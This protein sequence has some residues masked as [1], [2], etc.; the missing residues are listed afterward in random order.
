MVRPITLPSTHFRLAMLSLLLTLA[1]CT[2]VA[3]S[4]PASTPTPAPTYDVEE[5]RADLDAARALWESV[6]SDDYAVEY[7]AFMYLSFVPVRIVVRNGVIESATL[8]EGRA[9]GTP[10]PPGGMYS[11]LTIDSLF[12]TIESALSQ[13]AWSMNA[14]YDAN[15]GYPREFDASYTDTP[16]DYFSASIRAYQ[17]LA[18][19]PPTTT[20][21]ALS[22]LPNLG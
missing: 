19:P 15:L 11:V 20:P 14:K 21:E 6:G 2:D 10:V 16:D 4:T 8:L 22:L 18:P 5:A 1:A 3:T 9:S 7:I 13:P 12:D 17:P